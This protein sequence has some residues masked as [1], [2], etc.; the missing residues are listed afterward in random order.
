[1][2]HE[3]AVNIVPLNNYFNIVVPKVGVRNT[4]SHLFD[5]VKEF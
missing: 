3:F 1:L 2:L 4:L 5:A